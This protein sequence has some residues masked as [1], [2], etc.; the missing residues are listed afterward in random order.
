MANEYQAQSPRVD[1]IERLYHLYVTFHVEYPIYKPKK[2]MALISAG[3]H[4][5]AE[6][7]YDRNFLLQA[8]FV[9]EY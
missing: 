6:E 9:R 5:Q 3:P 1:S 4:L 8:A 7:D 2:D